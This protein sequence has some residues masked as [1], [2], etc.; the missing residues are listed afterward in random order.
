M[1]G[2][3]IP[4]VHEVLTKYGGQ[5]VESC[6]ANEEGVRWLVP[7]CGK[8]VD[9]KYLAQQESTAQVVGVD[10]IQKALLEFSKEHPELDLLEDEDAGSYKRLTGKKV[11]LLKGD[12]FALNEAVTGGK[13]HAVMDRGSMVAIDPSLREDYVSVLS[14]LVH[15]GGSILLVA[16]DR[17]TGSEEARKKGP[18]FSINE[19]EVRRLYEGKDWVK[20]ITLLQEHDELEKDPDSKFKKDGLTSMYEMFFLIETK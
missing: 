16:L 8:T 11:T 3:H 17:R 1:L 9:M 10:G 12:F 4:D 13:F 20:S 18:P 15:P 2:W 7:L 19:Q 14:K 5:I 6:P